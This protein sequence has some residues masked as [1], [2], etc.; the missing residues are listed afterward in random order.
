M[1]TE[2]FKYNIIFIVKPAL[3][4]SSNNKSVYKGQPHFPQ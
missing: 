1:D 2:M 3:K 4:G